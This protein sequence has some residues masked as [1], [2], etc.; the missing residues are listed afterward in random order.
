M[1]E[2]GPLSGLPEGSSDTRRDSQHGP[3]V[4]LSTCQCHK[5]VF[6]ATV[7]LSSDRP[8]YTLTVFVHYMYNICIRMSPSSDV[9]LCSSARSL[10]KTAAAE[11]LF[12]L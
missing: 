9:C 4:L 12:L 6:T 1:R 7:L 2:E 5:P 3:C 10:V 8:T 11:C